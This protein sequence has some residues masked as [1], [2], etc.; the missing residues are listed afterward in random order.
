MVSCNLND[1]VRFKLTP[2][3]ESVLEQYLKSQREKY[4][5]DAHEL[6]KSDCCGDI[7]L[8]LHDF[9]YV[10]GKRCVMGTPQVIEKNKLVFVGA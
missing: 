5:I 10:F 4:G 8:Y 1:K 7:R 6:Y 9:M 2:Y 3:G